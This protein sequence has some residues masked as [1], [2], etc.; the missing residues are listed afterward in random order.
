MKGVSINY[1]M[2]L[3]LKMFEENIR[4]SLTEVHEHFE[5][6]AA[7]GEIVIVVEGVES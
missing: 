2:R 4:G 1:N 3:K 6:K 7:K 5:K